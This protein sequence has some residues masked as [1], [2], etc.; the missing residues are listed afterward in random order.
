MRDLDLKVQIM[1]EMGKRYI[2]VI[3]PRMWHGRHSVMNSKADFIVDS[4]DALEGYPGYEDY[5]VLS[6]RTYL[7]PTDQDPSRARVL[8]QNG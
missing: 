8:L 2:D 7:G 1:K 6:A 5:V 3:E 4:R